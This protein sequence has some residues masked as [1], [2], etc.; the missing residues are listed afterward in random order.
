MTL[1]GLSFP[2]PR[3]ALRGGISLSFLEPSCRFWSHFVSIYCQKLTSS[4]VNR[5][6][7]Y[8]HEGPCV[9][10][11]WPWTPQAAARR[12]GRAHETPGEKSTPLKKSTPIQNR[13][14]VVYHFQLKHK[15]LQV[16]DRGVKARALLIKGYLLNPVS[17]RSH[18]NLFLP[19]FITLESRPFYPVSSR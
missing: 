16:Q 13:Q 14:L 5:L 15:K 3:E 18:L 2:H 10:T 11:P 8:P 7:K 19:R 17:S 12:A 4:L 6:L 1:S 9:V